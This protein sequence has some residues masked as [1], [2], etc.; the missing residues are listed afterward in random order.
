VDRE[1]LL[2][3][4]RLLIFFPLVLAGAYL[5]VKY[6]VG[7]FTPYTASNGFLQVVARLPV[8]PKSSLVV[9]RCG[10]RYFLIGVG[11]GPPVL[12]TELMDYGESEMEV[13]EG[14][15]NLWPPGFNP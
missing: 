5:T 6:G 1:F 14:R 2:A 15:E 11:E 10:R 7:R 12:L 13:W 4:I 3:L 9:V 8:S